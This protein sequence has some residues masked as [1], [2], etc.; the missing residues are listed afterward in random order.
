MKKIFI[1]ILVLAMQVVMSPA[2]AGER[3]L[4]TDASAE[5]ETLDPNLATGNVESRHLVAL[6]EGLTNYNPKTLAAMPGVAESWTV[7]PDG[8]AYTFIIRKNAKW[9][10]GTPLTADDF[11]YS[12]ERLLNPKTG[13]KY[14]SLMYV[15]KNAQAYN[16]GKITDPKLLGVTAKDP[17]TL[18]LELEYPAPYLTYL[19]S[20]HT[21]YPVPRQ[22][23]EKNGNAWT[24][25][26]NFVGNGPFVMKEWTPHK[27]ILAVKNPTY[28]DVAN[29]KLDGIRFWP[30]EDQET[31]VKLFEDGQL[32]IAWYLPTVKIP[33]LRTRPEYHREPWFATEYYWV[34]IHDPVLKDPR[35]RRALALAIDRKTLSEKFLY[36]LTVPLGTVTAIGTPNYTPPANAL[37]FNPAEAKK[38]LAEAGI[39]DPSAVTVEI[40]Y[41][42][43]DENKTVAQV[44]QQMWKQNLGITV[45]L[46][47]QE[48]KSYVKDMTQKNYSGLCRSGW[49]GDFPDAITFLDMFASNNQMNNGYWKSPKLDELVAAA[50][51][52]SNV[53]KR[54]QIMQQIEQILL[55][56]LPTI[57]IFQKNKDYMIKSYVKGYDSNLIDIHPWKFVSLDGGAATPQS[58]WM[59]MKSRFGKA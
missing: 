40:M 56:E 58:P 7:S 18:V 8:K 36:G 44:V 25:P 59:L 38:L 51:Q 46:R 57:P 53:Q 19:T 22:A 11:V 31:A 30:I 26:E 1:M 29:V 47:N 9:S 12:Y 52:E 45:T 20:F 6:F 33:A 35:V 37:T 34:N 41:N 21:F 15:L 55:T 39:K 13:G 28:W 43:K 4:N 23:I 16:T 2:M 48:W 3:Y 50:N 10:D 49:I 5:P 17:Q 32:D 27:S 42:T 24:R 54:A 14:A